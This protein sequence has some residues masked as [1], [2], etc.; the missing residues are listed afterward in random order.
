MHRIKVNPWCPLW[1]NFYWYTGCTLYVLSDSTQIA[2]EMQRR[3]FDGYTFSTEHSSSLQYYSCHWLVQFACYCC[4]SPCWTRRGVRSS[5]LCSLFVHS[6]LNVMLFVFVSYWHRLTL[7]VSILVW[8]YHTYLSTDCAQ[9]ALFLLIWSLYHWLSPFYHAQLPL[10]FLNLFFELFNSIGCTPMCLLTLSAIRNTEHSATCT[11]T[12]AAYL[13]VTHG[14][15]L[16][17]LLAITFHSRRV[18]LRLLTL[19]QQQNDIVLLSWW[20]FFCGIMYH[21]KDLPQS[22]QTAAFLCC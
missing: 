5:F 4:M 3:L 20:Y 6:P 11:C 9:V 2:L 1:L 7:P 12:F 14:F 16:I 15:H 13:F 10:E 19:Q 18:L 8:V 17:I 22:S 21:F